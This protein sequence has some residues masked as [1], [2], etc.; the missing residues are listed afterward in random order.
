MRMA[1]PMQLHESSKVPTDSLLHERAKLLSRTNDPLRQAIR[2]RSFW[3][4]FIV[5]RTISMATSWP[6]S[7]ADD[8][9]TVELPVTQAV[10]DL[11]FGDLTGTQTLHSP[12]FF[13]SHP[14]HHA[15][16]FVLQ[17][18]AL[19]LYNDIIR[20]F[21]R[22]ARG[23]HSTATY[24]AHPELFTCFSKITALRHSFPPHL[25]RAA[26][27]APGGSGNKATDVDL[28]LAVMIMYR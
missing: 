7:L 6:S 13:S 17:I 25:R 22:Y 2:D 3:M 11:G 12:D 14:P 21:R 5:E 8:E 24:L 9:I 18:K 26:Q 15:D 20:F 28:L 27:L 4:M 16:G 10:F 23:S 19:K 1:V